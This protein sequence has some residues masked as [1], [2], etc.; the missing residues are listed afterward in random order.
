MAF[1]HR[2]HPRLKQYD[3]SQDG[4][5]YVTI[6]TAA[7]GKK[8]SEII[9]NP[10]D[11]TVWTNLT[12]T[13]RIAQEQL[14]ELETR[15][16]FVRV[17][18]YVIMPTHIHVIF[19]FSGQMAGASPRPTLPEVI[20]TYKSLTTRISNKRDD[21]PGAKLFQGSFYES[22]LRNDADYRA[23]WKYIDENSLKWFLNPEDL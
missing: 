12:G 7:N 5:Y 22:V 16:P 11:G 20:G 2:K 8:L 10:E 4:Y 13:G 19:A 14:F 15:F 21:T 1:L 3:Y 18:K 9:K 6:H 17:D 23:R